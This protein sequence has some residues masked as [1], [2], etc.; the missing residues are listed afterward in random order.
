MES[1]PDYDDITAQ[2]VSLPHFT[3]PRHIPD[4]PEDIDFLMDHLND[5]NFDLRHRSK[6]SLASTE[7][8]NKDGLD[9]DKDSDFDTES[10]I[11]STRYSEASISDFADFDEYVYRSQLISIALPNGVIQRIALP[12]GARFRRQ[13]R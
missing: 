10:Q 3:T 9:K 13:H 5:P 4:V 1:K 11:G 7:I 6:V 12:G 8:P 2:V